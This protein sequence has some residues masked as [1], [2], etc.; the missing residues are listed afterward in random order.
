M[1]KSTLVSSDRTTV[2]VCYLSQFHNNKLR[3]VQCYRVKKLNIYMIKIPPLVSENKDAHYV[4]SVVEFC[5]DHCTASF[6]P[7]L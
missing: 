6:F 4:K 7:Y 3:M 1:G 5:N 2:I